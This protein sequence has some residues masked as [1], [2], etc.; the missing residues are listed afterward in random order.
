MSDML[1]SCS[2]SGLLTAG[3]P[4]T[5]S[6]SIGRTSRRFRA[7]FKIQRGPFRGEGRKG[8][9]QPGRVRLLPNPEL[10]PEIRDQRSV[11]QPSDSLLAADLG[12][13][14]GGSLTLPGV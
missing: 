5:S 3:F 14:S 6:T 11:T 8:R 7:G 9:A 4:E 2:L 10:R 1:S 12:S 13:G